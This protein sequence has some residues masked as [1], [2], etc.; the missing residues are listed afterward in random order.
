MHIYTRL[1]AQ[2]TRAWLAVSEHHP[3]TLAL[4]RVYID[5]LRKELGEKHP[6][7]LRG[8]VAEMEMLEAFGE[9]AAARALA[10]EL[11]AQF[12][13]LPKAYPAHS[14]FHERARRIAEAM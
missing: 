1:E 4:I 7:I 13:A 10:K 5:G 11:Q 12:L 9:H 2:R 14:V 8:R 3:D 6:S